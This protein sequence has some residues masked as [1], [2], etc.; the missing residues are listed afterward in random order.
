MVLD[1]AGVC[2]IREI[3]SPSRGEGICLSGID[4]FQDHPPQAPQD[5]VEVHRVDS[6]RVVIDEVPFQ[7][8]II[9]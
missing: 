3:F 2:F 8:S 4:A 6:R 1:G 7:R 9:S 5:E